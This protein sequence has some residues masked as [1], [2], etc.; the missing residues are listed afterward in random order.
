MT[1]LQNDRSNDARE[2]EIHHVYKAL[3]CPMQYNNPEYNVSKY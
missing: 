2:K 3:N 1:N